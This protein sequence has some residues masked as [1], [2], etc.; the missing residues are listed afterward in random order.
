MRAQVPAAHMD[1]P[2]TAPAPLPSLGPPPTVRCWTRGS[3]SPL[4]CR[5]TG[6]S[7]ACRVPST[8]FQTGPLPPPAVE[9][10]SPGPRPE[11]LL[12]GAGSTCAQCSWGPGLWR[13]AG[14]GQVA[15]LH[16]HRY[17]KGDGEVGGPSSLLTFPISSPMPRSAQSCAPDSTHTVVGRESQR[18][19][20]HPTCWQ[21]GQGLAVLGPQELVKAW[22]RGCSGC[23]WTP[24]I[25][26]SPPLLEARPLA[27]GSVTQGALTM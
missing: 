2:L 15:S 16:L 13:H 1:S 9:P 14:R 27:P 20:V 22:A 10:S 3:Q 23:D 8:Q 5:G 26:P 17:L 7:L 25:A 4:P 18:Q 19:R 24:S 6:L 11:P 21:V 12:T